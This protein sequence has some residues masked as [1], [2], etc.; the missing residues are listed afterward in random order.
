[1]KALKLSILALSLGLFAASCGNTETTT[2]ESTDT[3]VA[4]TGEQVEIKTET[5]EAVNTDAAGDTTKVETT[6]ET[7]VDTIAPATPEAK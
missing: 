2:I 6:T 7:N 4:P 5:T 3:L 1:M